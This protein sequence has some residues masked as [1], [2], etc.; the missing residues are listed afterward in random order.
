MT[1][2]EL[3][4]LRV[5]AC[6]KLGYQFTRS[7]LVYGKTVAAKLLGIT[8]ARL[9]SL[10]KPCETAVNPHY[11]SGPPVGLYCPV[12]LLQIGI[13]AESPAK[14]AQRS[15]AA[16]RAVET[17]RRNALAELEQAIAEL[18]PTWIAAWPPNTETA[19]AEAIRS[20]NWRNEY[21]SASLHDSPDFLERIT[22]N[23]LRHDRSD[24][25]R[26]LSAFR[27]RVGVR[28]IHDELQMSINACA[29]A[30]YFEA[31]WYE[32]ATES[33]KRAS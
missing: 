4:T 29:Y 30:K 26:L 25:E 17:K 18:E 31:G 13:V 16:L 8:S 33:L 5:A 12:A 21:K 23:Y 10:L 28:E 32:R 14:K 3:Q 20:Y 9:D 2:E 22:C 15:A 24:Y 1:P 7:P 19:V 6:A 11:K 27:G